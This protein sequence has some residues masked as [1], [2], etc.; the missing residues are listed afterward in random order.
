MLTSTDRYYDKKLDKRIRGA[1]VMVPNDIVPRP[2]PKQ[3][4]SL[5]RPSK[6]PVNDAVIMSDSIDYAHISSNL[7]PFSQATHNPIYGDTRTE[8]F[9]SLPL[10]R[11]GANEVKWNGLDPVQALIPTHSPDYHPGFGDGSTAVGVPIASEPLPYSH[12]YS[13][14]GTPNH[15]YGTVIMSQPLRDV[16]HNSIIG[17]QTAIP[18]YET[19]INGSPIT[20]RDITHVPVGAELHSIP[21]TS[22]NIQTHLL[23]PDRPQY[24]VYEHGY[25]GTHA[26]TSIDPSNLTLRQVSQVPVHSDSQPTDQTSA[27]GTYE[28][29]SRPIQSV[30]IAH[31]SG[32]N[33][34]DIYQAPA[35]GRNVY[36]VPV[37]SYNINYKNSETL[38]YPQAER[39]FEKVPFSEYGH[40]TLGTSAIDAAALYL[41]ERQVNSVPLQQNAYE[42][43]Y[44]QTLDHSQQ[45]LREVVYNTIT[46][47]ISSHPQ[48]YDAIGGVSTNIQAERNFVSVPLGSVVPMEQSTKYSQTVDYSQQAL[49]E[50]AYNTLSSTHVNVPTQN[51]VDSSENKL[52]DSNFNFVPIFDAPVLEASLSSKDHSQVRLH[53][54]KF[55]TI[56]TPTIFPDGQNNPY[57]NI[58]KNLRK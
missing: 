3:F 22:T 58:A 9:I 50:V 14:S 8:R 53:N 41:A 16:N 27:I 38:E 31:E 33:D 30:S 51:L 13:D 25:E 10:V 34:S 11:P 7:D 26:E 56:E 52:R 12:I 48:P 47:T 55:T 23:S 40:E 39:P 46:P 42:T 19:D 17:L 5:Y 24:M 1:P 2:V 36:S 45:A 57:P 28:N 43:P 6:I 29:A 44:S 37:D 32:I 35:E 15:Q 54:T 20:T 4:T 49:R 18:I 21:I